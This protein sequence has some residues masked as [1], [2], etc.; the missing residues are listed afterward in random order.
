MV[1]NVQA[2]QVEKKQ[3]ITFPPN[4]FILKMAQKATQKCNT[5]TANITNNTVASH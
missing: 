1:I 2:Q 4:S 5:V 3:P